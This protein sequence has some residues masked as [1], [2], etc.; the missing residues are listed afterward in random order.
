MYVVY[1]KQKS[2]TLKELRNN[3]CNIEYIRVRWEY[4]RVN[5]GKITQ[6]FNCQMFG[7]G[8]SRCKVKTF[9][10]KCAG[11]HLTADCN[12]LQE[13]C[14]NCN[15]PHK[16]MSQNCPSR[17]NYIEMKKRIVVPRTQAK[18]LNRFTNSNYAENFP[19]TL[20]QD[21]KK[22]QWLPQQPVQ[23]NDLFS[24]EELKTLSLELII[25]LQNCKTK[26]D[27]FEVITSL[28]C[29]FLSK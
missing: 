10:A 23:H 18:S 29:K 15:G 9:C 22:P 3:Y 6:C 5:K 8:S 25:N 2:I 16:A 14:A 19:N 4:Q 11:N 20:R 7:H 26:A 21:I 1:F 13:K 12:E 24:L 27:Q 28:A 17:Q